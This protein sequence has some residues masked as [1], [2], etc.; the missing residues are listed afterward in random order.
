MRA[1]DEAGNTD[2]TP[3]SFSWT[4]DTIAPDSN[5]DSGPA[6][7]TNATGATFAFSS[8]AGVTFTCSLDGGA[9]TGCSSPQAYSGLAD[10]SH[11]FAVLATDSAGNTDAS[12]ETFTWE[13]DTVAPD[14]TIDAQPDALAPAADAT[15]KF[16]SEDGATF[17]CSIDAGTFA[18]C[19][20]PFDASGLSDGSHVFSVR[21]TDEAGNTDASPASFTWQTDGTPPSGSI[22]SPAAAATLAGVTT[23]AVADAS[24]ANGV[25][26]VQFQ[27][28]GT[29]LGLAD[30]GAP[31]YSVNWDTTSA[32]NGPHTLTALITDTVGNVA[33]A[34]LDV[35][36]ANEA[37][38]SSTPGLV[39]VGPGY[40]GA[41]ARQVV[42]TSDDRAYI[43]AVDDSA[44]QV[45]TGSAVIR[46]WKGNAPGVPTA[47]S[48]V[49]AAN[50][51]RPGSSGITNIGGMDLRL[52]PAS[53]IV[54]TVRLEEDGNGDLVYQTFNTNTDQWSATNEDIASNVPEASRGR[55]SF[56]LA[57]DAAG[58]P[59]VVY[60]NGSTLYYI[61]REGGSWSAPVAL[62][63]GD[64]PRHPS[65]TFDSSGNL[66]VVWLD[67]GIPSIKY[68]ELSSGTWGGS[69]TIASG[70][71]LT[72]VDGDQGPSVA[73][74]QAGVPSVLYMSS[75]RGNFGPHGD[76]FGAVLTA[77]RAGDGTW[78]SDNPAPQLLAHAP[79]IYAHGDDIY[80]FLGH[81]VDVHL[82]YAIHQ[83][84]QPWTS[85][86][87][88]SSAADGLL[89]GAASVRFD[90]LGDPNPNI[91]DAAFYSEDKLHDGSKLA[92]LYYRGVVP[93]T[94][95]VPDTTAPTV[96]IDA[97]AT[98]ATVTGVVTL[99]ATAADDVGVTS[100]Q[101]KLDGTDLGP[102]KTAP[103]YSLDWDTTTTSD[104]PHELTAVARDAAGHSTTSAAVPVTVSNVVT[105]PP[106]TTLFG[107]SDIGSNA[108]YDDAGFA[109][110]FQVTAG[111]FGSL[112]TLQLYLAPTSAATSVIV[113]I[114]SD[115]G[116]DQ[117]DALLTQNT[118]TSPVAGDW[119][120][121][122]LPSISVVPGRKYW[123]AL[124]AP[125]G[126][127]RVEFQD[128]R[129]GGLAVG[130]ADAGDGLPLT[131]ISNR[132]PWTDGPLSAYGVN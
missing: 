104:G 2:A 109:E 30:R 110:A 3:A 87:Q 84:G 76:R 95:P 20:S 25:D 107:S 12:A 1:T 41:T 18:S 114:Y 128:A 86:T 125:T 22:T 132:G 118:L 89:D 56:A 68:K 83:P 15:F 34:T 82:G 5:I 4:V 74:T 26:G 79:Q 53:G 117:P 60:V 46:A 108:D 9:Y 8:E 120:P 32:S 11:T 61:V 123:I 63:T 113:G 23:V 94:P 59:H 51:P 127:G 31:P 81:D 124:L 129:T 116:S 122:L 103:P 85:E 71:V 36:V 6:A 88:L 97:P 29:D 69:E 42:R 99:Q 93:A 16:S 100:V 72:N 33:T 13:I 21:A 98:D 14:T 66:H 130:N 102:A 64:T 65:L 111:A 17:E 105:T 90:P 19:A 78:Q 40:V 43:F 106:G 50:H 73:V 37:V 57:V 126:A 44:F 7:L 54:H 75:S 10:G 131:W 39:P 52:D 67:E 62:D 92:F 58:R 77:F 48:E 115:N 49:D 24:D 35:T 38:T 101:F 28:D 55:T 91:I 47:F 121:I 112:T 70:D 80:A 119:N 45:H 96:G 27:L